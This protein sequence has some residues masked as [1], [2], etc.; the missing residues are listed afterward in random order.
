MEI[1]AYHPSHLEGIEVRDFEAREIDLIKGYRAQ[2]VNLPD[3]YTLLMHGEV[4]I[5]G[6]IH[7]QWP[8]VAE[9]FLITTPLVEKYVKSFHK[10]MIRVIEV[11]RQR[12]KLRRLQT[13]VNVKHEVSHG[14]IQHLG[15]EPEGI[16]RKYGPDGSDYVRYARVWGD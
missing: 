8:G 3:V 12:R 14:W 5:I 9:G 1:R 16:M 6:G 13:V 11:L 7:V 2:L 10:A 4:V 15:F